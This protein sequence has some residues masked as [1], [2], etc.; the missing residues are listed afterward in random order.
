METTDTIVTRSLRSLP[1]PRSAKICENK[2]LLFKQL[3]QKRLPTPT[4]PV[5][6]LVVQ[7]L[8]E[9]EAIFNFPKLALV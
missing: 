4:G 8:G 5:P 2:Q 6:G 1:E 9:S 3:I 7:A